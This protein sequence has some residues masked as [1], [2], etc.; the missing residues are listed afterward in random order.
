MTLARAL[1]GDVEEHIVYACVAAIADVMTVK[2]ET[3]AII[4]LGLQ[5]LRKGAVLP[6]Q[7]LANDRY[8]RWN[9]T[10]IAFQIVPKLNATGRLAT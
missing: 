4:K 1:I 3:R 9:E 8:P 5:Y 6:I 10:L 2:K 7:M